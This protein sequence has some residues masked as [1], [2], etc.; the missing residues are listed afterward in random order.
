MPAVSALQTMS[1]QDKAQVSF[2]QLIENKGL[3]SREPR[4]KA[5]GERAR[6]V[7]AVSLPPADSA[8][9][10][11]AARWRR[12]YQE[13][14]KAEVER[15]AGA[16]LFARL[17][18]EDAMKLAALVGIGRM[19]WQAVHAALDAM[20]KLAAADALDEHSDECHAPSAE[21][22]AEG[23]IWARYHAQ[24]DEVF[25]ADGSAADTDERSPEQ[26]WRRERILGRLR[27]A[28]DCDLAAA[29]RRMSTEPRSTL[30]AITLTPLRATMPW[31]DLSPAESLALRRLDATGFLGSAGM[32]AAIESLAAE[33]ADTI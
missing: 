7:V 23:E 28:R 6:A 32:Q 8:D 30:S 29:R 15:R 16:D 1:S 13:W 4:P 24:C 19:T 17:P 33:I 10:D 31:T 12:R 18:L 14:M 25:A 3:K 20:I 11:A 5:M 26:L 9:R 21:R 2:P 22:I 27:S